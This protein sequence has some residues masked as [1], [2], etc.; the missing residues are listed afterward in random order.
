MA[1]F[2]QYKAGD[3]RVAS[4]RLTGVAVLCS[5]IRFLV[6]FRY[7]KTENR[8]H[9]TEKLLT[10][11]LSVYTDKLNTRLISRV[12]ITFVYQSL[13]RYTVLAMDRS[14]F[15]CNPSTPIA[16]MFQ[17]GVVIPF[18]IRILIRMRR[19]RTILIINK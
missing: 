7:R 11:T 2:L 9:M 10:D 3:R 15:F 14:K 18:L 16:Y 1:Q 6:L 17:Y 13:S 4:S 8:P 5:F 19:T 12:C